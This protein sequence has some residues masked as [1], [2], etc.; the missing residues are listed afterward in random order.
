[1]MGQRV[2]EEPEKVRKR[3]KRTRRILQSAQEN[4]I[5]KRLLWVRQKGT[6]FLQRF[7]KLE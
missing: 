5:V 3:A 4:C 6:C 2:E 1:M 7:G